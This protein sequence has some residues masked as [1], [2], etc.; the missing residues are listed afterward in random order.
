MLSCPDENPTERE[1]SMKVT[2]VPHLIAGLLAAAAGG[3]GEGAAQDTDQLAEAV[4]LETPVGVPPGVRLGEVETL[5][6]A[7]QAARGAAALQAQFGSCPDDTPTSDDVSPTS[8]DLACEASFLAQQAS[9]AALDLFA[10]Y[11]RPES[12]GGLNLT[13]GGPGDSGIISC[14]GTSFPPIQ[15]VCTSA[16]D[17]LALAYYC[18]LNGGDYTPVGSTGVC[19]FS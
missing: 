7:A 16:F 10:L 17:C 4:G 15:C 5:F 8:P 14:Q 11:T 12:P 9:E 19:Q 3:C 6:A 18:A 1:S 13:S 2:I